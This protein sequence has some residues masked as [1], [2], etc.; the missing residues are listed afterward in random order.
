MLKKFGIF[1]IILIRK[2]KKKFLMSF[3]FHFSRFLIRLNHFFCSAEWKIEL[4]HFSEKT[5]GELAFRTFLSFYKKLIING[6][7]AAQRIGLLS[8]L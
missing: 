2:I 3:A 6:V 4:L 8:R 1:D 7:W 5:S